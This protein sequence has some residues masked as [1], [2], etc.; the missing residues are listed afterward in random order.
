[1]PYI[2]Q[3]NK[4][5]TVVAEKALVLPPA[6]LALLAMD[7]SLRALLVLLDGTCKHR[8]ELPNYFCIARLLIPQ[9][10]APRNDD[11]AVPLCTFH[12]NS[13]REQ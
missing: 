6:A 3:I 12:G 2:K 8:A 13:F 9:R 10:Y 1:M 7:Q 5:T 11:T 4:R